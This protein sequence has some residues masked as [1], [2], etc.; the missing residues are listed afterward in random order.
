MH[1]RSQA[2]QKRQLRASRRSNRG[3]AQNA[4]SELSIKALS[5][6]SVIFTGQH[7]VAPLNRMSLGALKAAHD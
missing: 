5:S 2:G 6:S 1:A 3:H 7:W 4:C